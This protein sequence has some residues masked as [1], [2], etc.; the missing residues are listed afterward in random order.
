MGGLD[1]LGHGHSLSCSGGGLRGGRCG[2]SALSP[3]AATPVGP[4][5][6]YSTSSWVSSMN[7]SS[8]DAVIGVSSWTRRPS[9]A[10]RSPICGAVRPS[11]VSTPA[12]SA[13][14]LAPAA[15]RAAVNAAASGVTSLTAAAAA[16]GDEVG[17]ARLGDQAA[18][19][20][21]DEAVG[22]LGHLADQVARHEHCPAFSGE[23]TQEVAY[24]PDPLGVEAVDRLVEEQNGGIAEQRRGDSKTLAHAEGE[25][26][27]PPVGHGG[28]AD[29]VEDLVDAAKGDVVCERQPSE[30]VAGRASGVERLG[31]EQTRQPRA[32]AR[33][34]R[35]RACRRSGPNRTWVHPGP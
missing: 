7:A 17:D 22:G 5:G 9:R 29:L 34:A 4:D 8:K 35:R 19:A 24:P 15:V 30:V 10:A 2:E 16:A 21:Y 3:G 11:M 28:Q 20:D 32:A 26:A 12:S 27:G 14:T 25:L 23:S 6:R 18:P 13:P 31:V 33:P 1:S